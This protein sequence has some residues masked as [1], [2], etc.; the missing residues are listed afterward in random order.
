M[1]TVTEKI[2]LRYK[3]DNVGFC[4]MYFKFDYNDKVKLACLQENGKNEKG[5]QVYEFLVC[6]NDGEPD[7]RL[8]PSL[9]E[10]PAPYD[11]LIID[12]ESR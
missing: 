11:T 3:G 8:K 6:S 7:F 4:R 5:E 12:H 9:F 1:S 2:K 10:F